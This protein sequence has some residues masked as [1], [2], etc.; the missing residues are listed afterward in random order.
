MRGSESQH[1]LVWVR[2]CSQHIYWLAQQQVA[3][4]ASEVER[5]VRLGDKE[6]QGVSELNFLLL[7]L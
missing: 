3:G 1:F 2:A 4:A 6:C 7:G 5:R